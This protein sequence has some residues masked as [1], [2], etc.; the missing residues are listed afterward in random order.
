MLLQYGETTLL[1]PGGALP[2]SSNGAGF[3]VTSGSAPAQLSVGAGLSAAGAFVFFHGLDSDAAAQTFIKQALLFLAQPANA[4]VKLAWFAPIDGSGGALT[5][6]AIHV[7]AAGGALTLTQGAVL[8]FANWQVALTGGGILTASNDGASLVVTP[9]G[10][11]NTLT[12]QPPGGAAAV[13]AFTGPLAVAVDDPLQGG[14]LTGSMTLDAA[15][16]AGLDMGLRWYT[17]AVFNGQPLPFLSSARYSLFSL[18]PADTIAVQAILDPLAPFAGTRTTIKPD[19][20]QTLSAAFTTPAAGALTISPQ[21]GAAFVPALFAATPPPAGSNGAYLPGAGQPHVYTLAPTGPFIVKPASNGVGVTANAVMAGLS[22]AEYFRSSVSEDAGISVIF[23]AGQPA[24]VPVAANTNG[25]ISYGAPTV[26]LTTAW[27]SIQ[28]ADGASQANYFS[29]PQSG[30]LYG[31]TFN[32]TPGLFYAELVSGQCGGQ[33]TVFPFVPYAGMAAGPPGPGA[34]TAATAGQIEAQVLAPLRRGAIP[35]SAAPSAKAMTAV[36]S[37]GMVVSVG[38]NQSSLQSTVLATSQTNP[39]TIGPIGGA[40]L[41]A[42]LSSR[43]FLVATEPSTFANIVQLPFA[44]EIADWT[45]DL[46]PANW[47]ANGTILVLKFQTEAL[48]ALVESTVGWAQASVFNSDALTVRERLAAIIAD[49]RVQAKTQPAFQD[50][51]T[52]VADNPLWNGLLAFNVALPAK[53]WPEEML[54]LV[55]G[56]PSTGLVAHHVGVLVNATDATRQ[57]I[58]SNVFGMLNYQTANPIIN[59]SSDYDFAVK[60]LNIWFR[61]SSIYSFSSNVLLLINRMFSEQVTFQAAGANL[62]QLFGTYQKPASGSGP[63]SYVFASA[64]PVTMRVMSSAIDSIQTGTIQMFSQPDPAD[65]KNTTLS[66]FNMNGTISFRAT[67]GLD[68]YSYGGDP[69]SFG[70]GLSFSNLSINLRFPVTPP[71]SRTFTF[72]ASAIMLNAAASTLRPASLVA[73]FPMK[74]SGFIAGNGAP[75]DMGYLAVDLP[76]DGTALTGSWWGLEFT[77]D[78]GSLG[79]L[80][81]TA[82]LVGTMLIGWNPGSTAAGFVGFGAPGVKVGNQAITLEQV[83]TLSF[84]TVQLLPIGGSQGGAGGSGQ[85]SG[86]MLALRDIALKVLSQTFPPAGQVTLLI[87]GNPSAGVGGTLGWM[88]AYDKGN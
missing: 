38:A 74:L 82:G 18:Q 27:A 72:D 71:I 12:A 25:S 73:N 48:S 87:F 44:L 47:A 68:L 66:R 6:V 81:D 28:A 4:D 70:S 58:A 34:L 55:A 51:I 62:V 29:Q 15:A 33:N 9:G 77:L 59:R 63:G 5:G 13:I 76:I 49:A 57:I 86:Y 65:P 52:N 17:D 54:G 31:A 30:I 21:A 45:F 23:K 16:V 84:G 20:G 80:A 1:L 24:Y 2:A 67:A 64:A 46:D 69:G 60:T 61:N 41:S 78:L 39:L 22:G 53:N 10:W 19:S 79:S 40:L 14:C 50:F 75:G 42:F 35:L 32:D 85:A 43:L 11:P 8:A 88:A 7:Q 26:W 36:N 56:L 83:L 3:L 37:Q